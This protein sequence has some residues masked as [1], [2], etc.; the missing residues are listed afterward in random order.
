IKHHQLR[1]YNTT[2]N[3]LDH[4]PIKK[5]VKRK[6]KKYAEL[7]A[8]TNNA[9][10]NK[11]TEV[12]KLTASDLSTFVDDSDI[13]ANKL[14]DNKNCTLEQ[15]LNSNYINENYYNFCDTEIY[16]NT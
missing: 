14:C 11:R 4:L 9:A 7:L 2:V 10:S 16:L 15:Q 12:Q 8:V 6:T 3:I 13:S 5:K 1:T